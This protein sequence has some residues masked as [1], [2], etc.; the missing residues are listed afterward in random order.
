MREPWRDGGGAD[1]T[2][3][4]DSPR[5]ASAVDHE[6]GDEVRSDEEL[7]AAWRAGAGNGGE[8]LWQRHSRCVQRFFCNKVPWAVA[9]DLAQRTIE[10]GLRLQKP[11]QSFRNYLLGIARHQLF[12]YLRSEQRRQRREVD[13]DTLVIEDTM[14]VPEDWVSEKREKRVLLR[15]LRHLPLPIQLAL[16]LRYWERMSDREISEV[17][18]IPLGTVKS[19]IATGHAELRAAIKRQLS[20]PERVRSTLDTLDSWAHRTRA[21]WDRARPGGR[22][23][24]PEPGATDPRRERTGGTT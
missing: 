20:S 3:D 15:A 23:D 8:I 21:S 22:Q 16:E 10:A 1:C 14:A 24:D 6:D 9:T 17:L 2:A 7:L 13:L 18:E 11:V 5:L 4:A 12:D 19:R